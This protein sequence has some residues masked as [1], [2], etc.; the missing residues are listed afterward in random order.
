MHFFALDQLV[1]L[2]PLAG[3]QYNVPVLGHLNG[4]A[5]GVAAVGD[6]GVG[7]TLGHVGGNLLNHMLRRFAVRVVAGDDAV[8]GIRSCRLGQLPAAHLGASA[9]RAEHA[10][11]LVGLVHPQR[12]Q[13]AGQ[14]QPVVGVVDDE[15][16]PG[17]PFHD[18]KPA[19]HGSVGQRLRSLGRAYA[20]RP[21]QRNG[22]QCVGRAELAGGQHPHGGRAAAMLAQK[23]DAQCGLAAELRQRG[24]V[25]VGGALNAVAGLVAAK[26]GAHKG[27]GVVVGIVDHLAGLIVRK[28]TVLRVFVVLKIGVLAGADVV[29]GQIGERHHLKRDAI[30]AVVAQR[31]AAHFQHHMVYIGVQHLAEQPVQ[32]QAFRGG[33]GGVLVYAR[34]VY[35]VRANV[36]A[37]QACLGHDRSGQQSGGRFAFGAGDSDDVQLVSWVAVKI[38]TDDGQRGAGVGRYDLRGVGGQVK[39]VLAQKGAAAVFVGAGG[40]GVAVQPGTHQADEQRPGR[41][42]AGIV[43]DGGDLRVR[44]PGVGNVLDQIVQF[45]KRHPLSLLAKAPHTPCRWRL[46]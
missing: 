44:S 3:E 26:A 17:Q 13:R 5:D 32:F 33:V 39:R 38:G 43:G 19:L 23:V 20:E 10:D 8:I 46:R 24:A 11:Q 41:R 25:V 35:A 40:V 7:R 37:G 29:L 27:A 22:A 2:V 14:R 15:R 28:Q 21:A 36:G 16:P 42:L 1:I 12:F 31:L 6:A 18:L 45:H 34:N 30:H 4:G 9:D